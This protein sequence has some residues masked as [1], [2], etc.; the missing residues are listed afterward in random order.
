M[1]IWIHLAHKS[2]TG[3]AT[4]VFVNESLFTQKIKLSML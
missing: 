2:V 1:G 3:T 4:I